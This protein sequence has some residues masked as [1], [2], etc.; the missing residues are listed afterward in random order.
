[1]NTD[2]VIVSLM[3]LCDHKIQEGEILLTGEYPNCG[4]E[5]TFSIN[6]EIKVK[7]HD[8]FKCLTNLRIELEKQ[9]YHI[10]CNGARRDFICGGMMRRGSCGRL[11]YISKLG[12]YLNIGDNIPVFDYAEPDLV[13]SVDKQKKYDDLYT[14]S[15][16]QIVS[17][18]VES[19]DGT[20]LIS[21]LIRKKIIARLCSHLNW[22]LLEEEKF[23]NKSLR[24][25]GNRLFFC[26]LEN[27]T[28]NQWNV[29]MIISNYSIYISFTLNND[30]QRENF[31]IFLN[32]QL[33][34]NN[35]QHK[36]KNVDNY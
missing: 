15:L 36:M 19:L 31:I 7:G 5:L 27:K 32:E 33:K 2:K 3:H 14:S 10:S 4:I 8:Y 17:Y 30:V 18:S 6:R 23:Y 24:R 12:K 11:G 22:Q 21:T 29:D 25:E 16:P 28:Q 26:F 34:S 35:I 13:V 20:E 9:N 1:M